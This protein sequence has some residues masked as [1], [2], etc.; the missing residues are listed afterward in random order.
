MLFLNNLLFL[1]FGN[2]NQTFPAEA[3]DLWVVFFGM[4]G[5]YEVDMCG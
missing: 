4:R 1:V 2:K 3:N 5:F